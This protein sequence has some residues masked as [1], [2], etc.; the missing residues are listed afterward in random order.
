[1]SFQDL[2]IKRKV[3]TVILLTSLTA[4]LLTAATFTVYDWVTCRQTMIQNLATS[5]A[6]AANNST[7]ALLFTDEEN[8]RQNLRALKADPNIVAAA[9]Y[10]RKGHIYVRYPSDALITRFPLKP[11]PLG[12]R[13]ESGRLV[14]WLPVTEGGRLAG[15]LYLQSDLRALYQR[16]RLYAGIALVILLGSVLV[17][18]GISSSLQRGITNPILAL[19]ESARLV[20]DRGDYSI[21]AAKTSG[22]ELGTL[23]DAFNLMLSRIQHQ[24]LALRESEEQRRLALEAS[25]V[26]T[27]NR[28]LATQR[29]TWDAQLHRL[30]GLEPGTFSG[31]EE[32]FLTVIHPD[33]RESV[34]VAIAKALRERTELNIEFRVVWADGSIHHLVSRGQGFYSEKGRPI[35]FT[36][37]TLDATERRQAEEIRSFLAAIVDSS[38]DAVVGKD[39]KSRVVSWNAGAERMFGYTAAEMLG[40][41][42]TRI[43]SPDRPDEEPA[44][45]EEVK[46]GQIR[47]FETVRVKKD[48]KPIDVSLTISPIKNARGDIIGI[49]SISR[50]ITE[51]KRA[52]VALEEHAAIL[53]EQ[54]QMLD[55]ANIMAR[56]LDD[57]VILWNAGMEKMYGWTKSE[58]I[59]RTSHELFRTC[60]P[61]QLK[62]I[63]EILFRDGHWEGELV[64]CRKHGDPI[65]VASQWILHRD[66]AGKPAA[67]LEV[68]NDITDKREAEAQVLKLN[69]ELEQRVRDR[70]A[71]LTSANQEMEA[72]TYSVAHDLRAPLRHIDAFARILVEDFA[73]ELPAE[74]S[75]YLENIRAG[76]RNM[77]R[78]V[79]DLLNLARVGREHLKRRATPLGEIVGQVVDDLR[80]ETQE[81]AIEWRIE[82]LPT[83]E[84]DPG[85][86]KQV[87]ANLLSNA[88]KYTRPRPMAVIEVGSRQFDG[89]SAL[90]VRDN[91]V[92]FNMKYADKL[93]GVFQRLHRAEEFEGTGVGLATVDRIIRKHGGSV[94]AEAEMGKGATFYF[95]LDHPHQDGN[96]KP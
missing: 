83:V 4:L 50:D 85:L 17:A 11:G 94:W 38:D 80:S 68:N 92:G 78:L 69:S 9:L 88:V 67:I 62:S 91:G 29:V 42:I 19:V 76:S 52:Q 81:R 46:K 63:R 25:R 23:T 2:P 44:V 32:D 15:T 13:F 84:C 35:R 56:D 6:I 71:E 30:F 55:L 65:F 20:S 18:L 89:E 77:S 64:H 27:W 47:H 10:D 22:D 31:S 93:F 73:P 51:S 40:Q 54:T 21:R 96:G 90:F 8:A 7:A 70:T 53:R 95:T 61:E 41:P 12:Y 58:A 36:G 59:G 57:R 66:P 37:V 28:D 34:K 5:G 1:M 48:G 39:M 16:P 87:F 72:F 45:Q 60:F 33:D 24:T 3:M 43:L 14:Y 75:R 86:I 74:A 82:P 26:G 49:S 79:D